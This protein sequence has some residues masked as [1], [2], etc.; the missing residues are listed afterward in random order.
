MEEAV[1]IQPD[2]CLY[3]N[4]TCRDSSLFCLNECYMRPQ[5]RR[6][7]TVL[8]KANIS[9]QKRAIQHIAP[10]LGFSFAFFITMEMWRPARWKTAKIHRNEHSPEVGMPTYYFDHCFPKTESWLALVPRC[11][12]ICESVNTNMA[13]TWE[14]SLF[15]YAVADQGFSRRRAPTPTYYFRQFFAKT[16]WYEYPWQAFLDPPMLY[17]PLKWTVVH[18]EPLSMG[19]KDSRIYNNQIQKQ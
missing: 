5:V 2:K 3:T 9:Y 13:T 15:V 12:F 19:K 6:D 17:V 4:L 18:E 8:E 11:L 14:M 1:T 16:A 7:W 10:I